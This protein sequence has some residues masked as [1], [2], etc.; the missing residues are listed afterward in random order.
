[1]YCDIV[2]KHPLRVRL[3]CLAM[4]MM[5]ALS[6]AMPAF[7]SETTATTT[8]ETTADTTAASGGDATSGTTAP[9][10]YVY[11]DGEITL[12]DY[13]WHDTPQPMRD[14]SAM[15]L[16]KDIHLGWN[17]GD[18]LD[19][20]ARDA[21]YNEF[22]NAN[23]YQMIIRY[24]DAKSERSTSIR[25]SF[26]KNNKATFKWH[27]G[28]IESDPQTK[29]G[30]IGFEIWNLAIEEATTVKVRCHEAKLKRRNGAVVDIEALL[31]D[32]EVTISKYG[33]GA[34]LVDEFPKGLTKTYG[35]TDGEFT[36]TLELIEFP[37]KEY[38]K[39][40]YF[41]TLRNN[42]ITTKEMI[43]E[44]KRMG[45]NAVRIPVT[46]YNHILS[47]TDAIDI[48]WLDRVQEVVDYVISQDMYCIIDMHNDGS[49]TGW[50]KVNTPSSSDVQTRYAFLWQQIA[51]R[52]MNYGD[53]L[54]FQ[55]FNE[56]TDKEETW[57]YPGEADIEWINS[58]NQLFVDT[59]RA[60]GGNNSSRHLML[61]PY[62]GTYDE[63]IIKGFR[64]PEDSIPNR[65]MVSV[66]AYKPADFS[67]SVE[68]DEDTSYTDVLEWGGSEDERELDELFRLLNN[69]FVS[70]GIPV[71]ITEFGSVD[72]DNTP[73]RIAHAQYYIETAEQYGIPCF[74]WDDGHLLM[75]KSL[76]WSTPELVEAM[77]DSTTIHLR[78]CEITVPEE[79]FFLGEPV[80]PPVSITF[81]GGR[82]VSDG[83][84][85]EAGAMTLTE[86][87][88]YVVSYSDNMMVGEGKAV[89][90]AMGRYSGIA[91]I[92]YTIQEEPIDVGVLGDLAKSDPD[93]PLVVMLS[94]PVLLILA[95]VA[96]LQMMNRRER[97][98][99][100]AIIAASLE[101]DFGTERYWDESGE[102]S[103]D[104]EV[105]TEGYDEYEDFA[106]DYAEELDDLDDLD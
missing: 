34:F 90:T 100:S 56:L 38:G 7:A 85:V 37:Q 43:T 82:V 9:T 51:C 77:V 64:M 32:H 50:L 97:Q 57:E 60:T 27:T 102:Y 83:D 94:V 16:V 6:A 22:H 66:N 105:M 2:K 87:I 8:A 33:T 65:L 44:V 62:A 58:L 63:E 46:Y 23:S 84:M 81:P 103:G 59:V 73:S 42:P 13:P 21:G 17:L 52:F 54:I 74:W 35:I 25:N 55:S 40:D 24:D 29:L 30:D 10:A 69:V 41:E 18:T 99:T 47:S 72:K 106:D 91:E 11:P 26:D 68:T 93:L 49:P 70:K 80:C 19:S 14:I 45:F 86:G 104:V 88:D 101:E 39:A 15:E 53:K 31:G 92:A 61:M 4:A 89:I 12:Q 28:L 78:R 67:W 36:L 96:F 95:I 76:T 48:G 1:M 20:W 71:V 75:R 5:M 79:N 98:R 3:F